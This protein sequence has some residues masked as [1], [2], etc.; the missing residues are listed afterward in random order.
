[1]KTFK[2]PDDWNLSNFFFFFFFIKKYIWDGTGVWNQW[3]VDLLELKCPALKSLM[4]CWQE[5]TLKK[6]PDDTLKDSKKNVWPNA[7]SSLQT[8]LVS[9]SIWA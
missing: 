8:V 7:Y 2:F 4:F 1:M 3:K 5:L 6:T 9:R